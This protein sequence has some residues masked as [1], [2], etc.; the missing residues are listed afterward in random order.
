MTEKTPR[1]EQ[2]RKQTSWAVSNIKQTCEKGTD[3]GLSLSFFL[4]V[5]CFCGLC[6]LGIV[7][8]LFLGFLLFGI[9]YIWGF[10]FWKLCAFS[11]QLFWTFSLSLFIFDLAF[12]FVFVQKEKKD[13]KKKKKKKRQ[14]KRQ[15]CRG[16]KKGHSP[17]IYTPP[18]QK[19]QKKRKAHISLSR[20]KS[21]KG[22]T[23][24]KTKK[25][26]TQK[27]VLC[28]EFLYYYNK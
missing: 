12:S 26:E 25:R 17:Y 2:T 21:Q 8:P 19:K 13:Q 3:L 11:F 4:F 20:H 15:D 23:N 6:F 10:S 5:L 7:F 27:G 9:L 22:K 18:T 1:K 16:E 28:G 24:R 14:K